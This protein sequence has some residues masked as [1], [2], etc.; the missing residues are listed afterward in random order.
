MW[1]IAKKEWQQFFSGLTGYLSVMIF[2]LVTGLLLFVFP[3]YNILDYGYATL[4]SFFSIIPYLLL[5][6]IPTVT[7]RSFADE[8][9]AGT[10]ETLR[11]LPLSASQLVTGKFFG[12]LL[13]VITALVPTLIYGISVQQLSAVGGID[14]GATIGSYIGLFMLAAVFTAAGVC[15]SSFTNNTVIAFIAAAFISFVLYQGFG[16][17]SKLPVFFAGADYYIEMLGIDFHYKS[18]SRGVIDVRDVIY[19]AAITWLFLL[20]T[21]RN[22]KQYK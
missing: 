5:F 12:N 3:D 2:L 19:F 13:V 16:A 6:L 22:I 1:I 9:K 14:I 11:T 7:M 20:I 17:L 21:Q 18:V 8:Y 15:T 10:F 4:D